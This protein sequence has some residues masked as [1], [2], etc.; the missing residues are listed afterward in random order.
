MNNSQQVVKGRIEKFIGFIDRNALVYLIILF[1]INIFIKLLYAGGMY[2]W[3]DETSSLFRAQ[4][5]VIWMIRQSFTDPNP[6]LYFILLKGWISVFG[7]SELST[8]ALSVI[9][10]ALTVF[11]LYYLARR[12]FNRETAFYVSLIFTV[13]QIHLYFSHET[14]GYTLLALMATLSFYFYLQTISIPS[15]L[16]LIKYTVTITLLLYVH[17]VPIILIIIQFIC[18]L[19]YFRNNRKGTLYII[20]GQFIAAILFGVWVLKNQWISKMKSWIPPPDPGKLKELLV[21]YLNTE[22]I[23]YL[24]VAI[25]FA[26][27]VLIIIRL[28]QKK[29]IYEDFRSFIL[30]LSWGLLPILIIYFISQYSSRFDPRYIL[31]ATPGLYLLIAFMISKLPVNGLLRISFIV[32]ILISSLINFNLK[33]VKGEDWPGAIN[34]ME[35]HRDDSTLT[36]ICADYQFMSFSYYYNKDIFRQLE[37]APK[38]LHKENIFDT[39]GAGIFNTVDLSR[40]NKIILILS[41]EVATDPEGILFRYLSKTYPITYTAPYLMNIKAYVFDMTFHHPDSLLLDFENDNHFNKLGEKSKQAYSGIH[42]SRINK[43]TL[44]SKGLICAIS[45]IEDIYSN[46]FTISILSYSDSLSATAELV[47]SFEK[48]DS[49]YYWKS[50][51]I[52]SSDLPGVWTKTNWTLKI[53]HVP[54]QNDIFKIYA[55]NLGD[56]EILFDDL[57]IVFYK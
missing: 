15:I 12:F 24:S 57:R 3:L 28:I 34:F 9:F 46:Y 38:I 2:Y 51:K 35:T 10:S 45:E 27:I 50:V 26:F 37:Q 52:E 54:L 16:N 47:C 48:P 32:L 8:R 49:I 17:P 22:F 7:I 6:P 42:V 53:P 18:L 56:D 40:Y 21:T 29:T 20:A 43:D 23:F 5:P 31:F 1:S 11:I 30:I 41:H 33:P 4:H 44:Y 55:H 13:S 39:K 36:L 14:R 19:F 25:L